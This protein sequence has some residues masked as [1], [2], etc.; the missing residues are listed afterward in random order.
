MA[1]R[2]SIS[3]PFSTRRPS[4][5]L[6]HCE[7][8]RWRCRAGGRQRAGEHDAERLRRPPPRRS[9]AAPPHG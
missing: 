2:W 1:W 3:M 4:G 8:P 6:T 5:L 9:G 7:E